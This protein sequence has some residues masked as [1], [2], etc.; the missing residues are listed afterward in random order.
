MN[1]SKT[2]TSHSERGT[3]REQEEPPD[4]SRILKGNRSALA[5]RDLPER[6]REGKCEVRSISPR[7]T[8]SF[9]TTPTRYSS[10]NRL[11][12]SAV[13]TVPHKFVDQ[14]GLK[15]GFLAL[16]WVQRMDPCHSEKNKHYI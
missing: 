11:K 1:S 14:M 15:K 16:Q 9:K 2:T 6:E 10:L 3:A 7:G 13:Q 8:T 5:P 4:T 12:M